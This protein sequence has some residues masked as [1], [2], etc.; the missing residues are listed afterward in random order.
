MFRRASGRCRGHRARWAIDS[1]LRRS[2]VAQGVNQG[3][4]AQDWRVGVMTAGTRDGGKLVGRAQELSQLR[5]LVKC[6]EPG[7]GPK[8][9]LIVGDPG[10]GK[11]RLLSEA[12]QRVSEFLLLRLVGFEPERNVP[13]GAA[14]SLFRTLGERG[15][16]GRRLTALLAG[17]SP[18]PEG[19]EA[20]RVFEAAY[21]SLAGL[22]PVLLVVDDLQWL[23]DLS[24]ALVHYLLRAALD[25]AEPLV[26]LCATRPIGE[27]VAFMRSVDE[28]FEDSDR[29]VKLSLGPLDRADGIELGL[30]ANPALGDVNAE[31]LWSAGRGSPFWILMAARRHTDPDNPAG[32]IVEALRALSVDGSACLAALVV[33]GRPVVAGDVTELLGWPATQ[34]EA[35]LSELANHGLVVASSGWF[36]MAHDLVREAA[37]TQLSAHE[38][39]RLHA[40]LAAQL[41]RNAGN[42]VGVLMEALEHADAAGVATVD[43]GLEIARSPQRRLLGQSGLDRLDSL[44]RSPTPDVAANTALKVEL[45]GL[46]E[47]LGDYESACDRF[48]ALCEALPTSGERAALAVKAATHA[49]EVGRSAQMVALLERARHDAG[50]DP[51][52]LVA[53]N[54]LEY[55][56][57][58][59][60]VH[61]SAAARPF[62]ERA[63]AA[64]RH[65]VAVAGPVDALAGPAR[66]AYLVAVDAERIALLMDD[67]IV[68]MLAAADEMVEASRGLGEQHIDARLSACLA[69]CHLNLWP[70]VERR[71]WTGLQEARQQI[72]PG[73]VVYTTYE[74]ALTLYNLSRVAEAR[75]LH[76][77]ARQ[78]GERIDSACEIADTW[79][80]GLRQLIDASTEDWQGAITSLVDEADG[81]TNPHSR[82]ILRQRAAMCAARF[83]SGDSGDLVTRLLQFA[84]CDAD[85]ADCVRCSWELRLVTAEL[86]ARVGEVQRAIDLLAAWDHAHPAPNARAAFMR[87]RAGAVL[88]SAAADPEAPALLA[89]YIESASTAG[90]RLEELWGLIDLGALLA[91]DEPGRA[92][93]A[94]TAAARLAAELGAACEEALIK[95]H[96][97]RLGV[98]R[99]SPARRPPREASPLARL[100]RRELEVARLAALG[101]RNADIA[102]SLFIS[103]RTVEQHLS[104]VFTKLGVRNRT[105]LGSRY[106]GELTTE[107]A[108]VTK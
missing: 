17:E 9:A 70:E 94:W 75:E 16:D 57:L 93:E 78:L 87:A 88:A 10:I 101:A 35:A 98:R 90:T 24:R 71:L 47:E 91:R 65:L 58:V 56:R 55:H 48:A 95:R 51:W 13:L 20:L 22:W 19:L 68:G 26:V 27:A 103:T 36:S 104:R 1:G 38:M 50:D 79:L 37:M 60:L 82:L 73:L 41:Q 96:L 100:S 74:L 97:R 61:D 81:Q 62:R 84:E 52:I 5:S 72:Y 6:V 3:R 108:T 28:L 89:Q 85:A 44:A 40:R 39:G 2:R 107:P 54:A 23:D 80:C 102:T 45:A 32:A 69:L 42:D 8:A 92:I 29:C 76:A 30:A 11:T 15:R 53:A 77:E 63:V 105:E 25:D 4:E 34:V 14:A 21:R 67:D 86:Y 7:R 49:L 83:A 59:W 64:A 106:G 33:A 66:Q 12:T 99:V 18:E 31:T 46:A 43:L